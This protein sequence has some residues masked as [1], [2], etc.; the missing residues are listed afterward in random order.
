MADR[1]G[2]GIEV[3]TQ[4]AHWASSSSVGGTPPGSITTSL[5]LF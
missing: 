3:A 4:R 2:V 1:F 5:Q